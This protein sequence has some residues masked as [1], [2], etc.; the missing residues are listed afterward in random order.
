MSERELRWLERLRRLSQQLVR[1][2]DVERLYPLILR[3]AIELSEAERGFLVRLSAPGEGRRFRVM[4]ALGFD[5][6]QLRSG[7][8][9][10]SRTVVERVIT[11]ERGLVTTREEDCEVLEVSSVRARRVRSIACAPLRLRGQLCGA[12]YVDHRF[13]HAAFDEQDLT[14][15]QAFADQA[16]LA[17][18]TAELQAGARSSAERL[19][20][21]LRAL[22]RLR[23]AGPALRA[24]LPPPEAT[25]GFG[26]LIGSS[27][28][29]KALYEGIE[30][31]S[32]SRAPA[33]LVGE[34]GAGKALAAREL[35]ARSPGAERP[36]GALSCLGLE[37]R[38]LEA[39]LFGQRDLI[40]TVK[41]GALEATSPGTLLLRG[42]ETCSSRLQER[43]LR[44]LRE[45]QLVPL[46]GGEP[47]PHAARVVVALSQEPA[48]LVEAGRL[49]ADL[50][51]LLE[52][53]R[54][55][56]PPLRER[57]E[58]LP[59]LLAHALRQRAREPFHLAAGVLD[60]LVDYAW[61][62]NVREL[63]N[64]AQRLAAGPGRAIGVADL[65]PELR[66]EAPAL[67][68]LAEAK[69]ELVEL[70]LRECEGQRTLAAKKLGIPRSTFYRLLE[71][72][73]L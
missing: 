28:P 44:A 35:H 66:E 4:V 15:L 1:E 51:L 10:V 64:L 37:E 43:L 5:G 8:E 11:S 40:G 72:Y 39:A 50:T 6:E 16:A 68:T 49:R 34:S 3:S 29:M 22:E 13:D 69:R 42:L 46:G 12:L 2:R 17:L 55:E 70:A 7:Q 53:Q 59:A 21:S 14:S 54:L 63:E 26:R 25:P 58:D 61:P 24:E 45:G 41:L 33:L 71:R 52:V 23:A 36:F 57:P 56:V 9:A 18:E 30:R 38:A 67:R 48:R 73:G 62:G 60:R 32:R 20:E 31:A 47:R 27:P 65:P 19:G